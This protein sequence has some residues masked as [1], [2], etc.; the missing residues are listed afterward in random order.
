MVSL[1]TEGRHAPPSVLTCRHL[2]RPCHLLWGVGGG[3]LTWG[4]FLCPRS[5]GVGRTGTFIVID[6]M[7]D[8]MH[9]EQKVD[10]FEFVARI[11]NQRPQMVQT[12]VSPLALALPLAPAWASQGRPGA[13]AARRQPSACGAWGTVPGAAILSHAAA[14]W[15]LCK[16]SA[17]TVNGP[18]CRFCPRAPHG[19]AVGRTPGPP[20][21]SP[22]TQYTFIYQ[23]LLEHH[24]Y[25]DT[26]LDVSSLEKHLQTLQ[27][28]A[29]RFN[30]AGLEEEFRVSV[31]GSLEAPSHAA[32]RADPREALCDLPRKEGTGSGSSQ[33]PGR[34]RGGGEEGGGVHPG[35]VGE[36]R[37]PGVGKL[38]RAQDVSISTARPCPLCLQKLTN[39]RIMKENMRTGNLPAN[40]KKARVIQIIPCKAAPGPRGSA[41]GRAGR[42]GQSPRRFC[43][44]EVAGL[45]PL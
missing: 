18:R 9:A 41:P 11:R 20:A 7:M 43:P 14:L 29:S 36:G 39:V 37:A 27:G 28:T 25:G 40:M 10:V 23:A 17:V 1:P 38:G 13:L 8:M 4:L 16:A 5:A 35:G 32:P 19:R 44:W 21:V 45:P 6:A 12:D 31:P 42:A 15:S 33:H 34:G 22:Q 24:L 30:K 3:R 2:L 26:E